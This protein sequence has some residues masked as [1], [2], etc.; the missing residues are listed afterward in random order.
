MIL[1]FVIFFIGMF[2]LLIRLLYLLHK[3]LAINV[4]SNSDSDKKKILTSVK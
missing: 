2:S 4:N 3:D 1:V